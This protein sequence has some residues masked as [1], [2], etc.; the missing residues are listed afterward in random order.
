MKI[1]LPRK[2]KKQYLKI[3]GAVNYLGMQMVNEIKYEDEPIKKN[4]QFP[5]FDTSSGTIKIIRYY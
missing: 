3:H 4:T 5:E 1:K 2:R